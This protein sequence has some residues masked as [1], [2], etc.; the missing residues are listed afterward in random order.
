MTLFEYDKT[1]D[2]ELLCGV[3]EAGRGPLAGDVFTAAVILPIDC[4]LPE[5]NDSKK[6]TAKKREILYDLIIAQAISYSI[7]RGTVE[8]ILDNDI[9]K[10]TFM[11]MGRAVDNLS[12]QPKLVLVDGNKNPPLSVHS[13]CIIGGD[14][15][16][17]CI[18][19]ASIL[20][21]V[22]RDRYMTEQ[23]EIY[24]EY[25]FE[26][27]A[28]YGTK[29]HYQRL[30]QYGLCPI[31]RTFFLRNL[32]EKRAKF[33]DTVDKEKKT[34]GE[35]GEDFVCNHLKENGY[36]IVFK[37]YHSKYGEIDIIAT[38]DKFIA[39]VEVKTRKKDALIAGV[40]AVGEKKQKRIINTASIYLDIMEEET[41]HLQ[42]RFD[43]V[44]VYT[45]EAD[46]KITNMELD[47][48]ENAFNL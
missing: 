23:A 48:I 7:D 11:S 39:F 35:L 28:G 25:G 42:P 43:V 36:N 47:Y 44:E 1:H 21:K 4:D 37:N 12:I 13:R 45:T 10:A 22:A 19:A 38:N 26:K 2:C 18:A 29:M 27:H 20:A 40:E 6:L 32:E 16:S 34:K 30:F 46:K 8:E 31:H 33:Y 3:D 24:P 15:T 17:A 14:K 41:K 9:L 5:L